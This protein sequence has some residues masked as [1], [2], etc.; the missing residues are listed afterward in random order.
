MF[1]SQTYK[2]YSCDQQGKKLQITETKYS[3]LQTDPDK[4]LIEHLFWNYEVSIK[5][6]TKQNTTVFVI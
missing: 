2:I 5:A 1:Q 6:R 4:I 3:G